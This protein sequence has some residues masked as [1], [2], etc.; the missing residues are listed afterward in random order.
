MHRIVK[1]NASYR[2]IKC[3]EC[4]DTLALVATPRLVSAPRE[5]T[6]PAES[7]VGEE[8]DVRGRFAGR[9]AHRLRGKFCWRIV[10]VPSTPPV[11]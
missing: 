5:L 11:Q 9:R 6:V 4:D 10:A 1:S 3:I 7:F 2:Q 8:S